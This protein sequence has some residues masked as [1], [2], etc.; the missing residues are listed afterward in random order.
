MKIIINNRGF[1]P[2]SVYFKGTPEIITV[3]SVKSVIA[4][5]V[6]KE[7][8]MNIT[9]MN[10][11]DKIIFVLGSA[12]CMTDSP[13]IYCPIVMLVFIISYAPLSFRCFS[14]SSLA[15]ATVY[16]LSFISGN[17]AFSLFIR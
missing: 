17:S 2:L 15:A 5:N 16:A 4:A 11:I 14:S 1:N 7:L 12:L 10:T 6:Q 9:T 8:I 13:G 3:I